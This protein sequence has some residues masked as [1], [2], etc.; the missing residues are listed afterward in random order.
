MPDFEIRDQLDRIER[1]QKEWM[2]FHYKTK[3]SNAL[4]IVN[5][6]EDVIRA[7]EKTLDLV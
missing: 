1:I 5:A 4:D 3:D 7:L 6:F 2:Y